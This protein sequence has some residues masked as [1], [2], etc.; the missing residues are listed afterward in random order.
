MQLDRPKDPTKVPKFENP[1]GL[2]IGREPLSATM[3]LILAFGEP[4]SNL[5]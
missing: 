5:N 3:G 2:E 1:R 4:D